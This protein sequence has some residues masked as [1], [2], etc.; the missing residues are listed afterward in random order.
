MG[1]ATVAASWTDKVLGNTDFASGGRFGIESSTDG[2]TT[3]ASHPI[4]GPNPLVFTTSATG[5]IPG[6]VVYAPLRLRTESGSTAAS[7]RLQPAAVLG[8]G[9]GNLSVELRYRVVRGGATCD[10]AAF[11]AASTFVVGSSSGSVSLNVGAAEDFPLAAGATAAVPGP[12]VP[13]CFEIALPATNANWTNS[14]L[15]NKTLVAN[16]PFVGTS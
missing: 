4:G 15:Q 16:W 1:A 5:L 2:G 8:T 11:G 9:V 7:V 12:A 13:L 3:W 10:A 14:A 6:S